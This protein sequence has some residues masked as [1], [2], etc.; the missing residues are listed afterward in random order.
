M[1]WQDRANK[2]STKKFKTK[3]K[4]NYASREYDNPYFGRQKKKNAR[5]IA[6]SLSFKTKIIIFSVLVFLTALLGWMFYSNFFTIS[7]I[8]INGQGRIPKISLEKTAREQ[9]NE[10]FFKLWPQ[11][12]IFIFNSKKLKDRLEKKY[13]FNAL[14][15]QKKLPRTLII[16][17]QEKQY[18]LI[19]H[20]DDKYY[21]ADS[22]GYII[23]EANPL[24]IKQ[25]DYPLIENLSNSKIKDIKIAVKQSYLDCAENLFNKFK[26]YENDFKIERFKIDNDS[27]VLKVVLNN[28]PELYFNTIK[29]TDKQINKLLILK[30]E[31]LKDDFNN[32]TYINLGYGDRVYYR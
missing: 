13:V 28:G 6:F 32:K 19:W 10:S 3:G 23:T 30:R 9:I 11:K 18:A 15:I 31:K 22:Q 7:E 12:N 26:D 17:Y 25:K 4:L 1:K 14:S 21:Y 8:L 20:E 16:N 24:E 5:I 27:N 29:D 2:L